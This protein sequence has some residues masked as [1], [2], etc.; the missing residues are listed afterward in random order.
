VIS[1]P[2]I[3]KCGN[4]GARDARPLRYRLRIWRLWRVTASA[5]LG[6]NC[7]AG[8]IDTASI[9][10]SPNG[11]RNARGSR[12][13]GR[14]VNAGFAH[15]QAGRLDRAEALYRKVLERDPDHAEAL[16][17]LGVVVHQRGN[18]AAAIALIGRAL[19]ELRDLPEAHLNLGNA[20]QEAR[21]GD[22]QLSAG[23]RAR[24]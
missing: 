22:R 14:T 18:V 24:S 3:R 19:P 9:M 13:V 4:F 12:G 1:K 5:E 8:N 11:K 10:A 16:H 7:Q 6:D 2:P 23:D 20:L 21:R 17:L 15:H